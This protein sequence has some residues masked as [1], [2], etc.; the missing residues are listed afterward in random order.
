[1]EDITEIISE[2]YVELSFLDKSRRN[3]DIN[4]KD[5][6]NLLAKLLNYKHMIARNKR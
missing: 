4:T 6:W 5:G 3:L 1:M 2:R